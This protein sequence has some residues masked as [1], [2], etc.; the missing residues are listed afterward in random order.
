[1]EPLDG[2]AIAGQLFELFERDMTTAR[3]ACTHCGTGALIAELRVYTRAPGPV[4]RC[5]HCGQVVF[6]V[7][8]IRGEARIDLGGFKLLEPTDSGA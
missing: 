7:T 3:G 6:V 4:A 1:V 8:E 5:R 2:N